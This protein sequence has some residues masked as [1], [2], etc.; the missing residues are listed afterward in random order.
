[1]NFGKDLLGSSKIKKGS[2][3]LISDTGLFLLE[4]ANPT[5]APPF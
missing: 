2:F 3:S 5:Q 4:E 1:M